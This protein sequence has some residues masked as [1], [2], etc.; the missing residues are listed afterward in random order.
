MGGRQ[1]VATWRKEAGEGQGC[2][3]SGTFPFSNNKKPVL[4]V[5]RGAPPSAP[6]AGPRHIFQ[7]P[8]THLPALSCISCKHQHFLWGRAWRCWGVGG[9]HPAACETSTQWLARGSSWPLQQPGPSLR[10]KEMPLLVRTGWSADAPLAQ[11]GQGKSAGP[12]WVP[13]PCTSPF[14]PDCRVFSPRGEGAGQEHR[15]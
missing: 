7:A 12:C 8:S 1:G 9:P 3:G 5:Q 4:G 13:P 6:P 10:P 11:A 2:P 15:V 14:H